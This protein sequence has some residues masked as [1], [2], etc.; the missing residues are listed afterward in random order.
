MGH[1]LSLY[2]RLDFHILLAKKHHNSTRT[3]CSF[4]EAMAAVDAAPA[5][6]TTREPTA[7]PLSA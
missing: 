3:S 5:A 4:L 1:G 6:K 2:D 7:T